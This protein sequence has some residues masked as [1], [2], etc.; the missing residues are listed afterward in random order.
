M[1]LIVRNGRS[2]R[3]GVSSIRVAVTV[4]SLL[5]VVR[6][7]RIGRHIARVKM[8]YIRRWIDDRT[9]I[10]IDR[11]PKSALGGHGKRCRGT[12]E[13]LIS[14][15]YR[16]PNLRQVFQPSCLSLGNW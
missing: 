2:W 1:T 16:G 13:L 3:C 9:A 15:L 11:K 14:A 5:W 4:L 6:G 7:Y 10:A 8:K 12:G